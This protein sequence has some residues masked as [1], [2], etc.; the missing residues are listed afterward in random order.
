[1]HFQALSVGIRVPTHHFNG[2]VHSVF[3]QACNL[4]LRAWYAADP[5][6]M[7]NR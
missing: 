4:W 1:M 6:S 3:H 7:P 5:P 2:T